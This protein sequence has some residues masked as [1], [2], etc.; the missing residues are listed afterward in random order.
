MAHKN[1]CCAEI[2]RFVSEGELGLIYLEKFREFGIEYRDGGTSYQHIKFCPFCGACF[3]IS[4]RDKWFDE[5]EAMG[6]DPWAEEIPEEYKSCKWWETMN[7]RNSTFD[8]F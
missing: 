1:Y 3:P 6:I 2:V 8:W 4:L 5:I 7:G